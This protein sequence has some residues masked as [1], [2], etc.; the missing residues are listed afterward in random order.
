MNK[1][2]NVGDVIWFHR[3]QAG[4]TQKELARVAGIGK[5]FDR[6]NFF[7]QLDAVARE[8]VGTVTVEEL[9]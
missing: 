2:E 6:N 8:L 3:Q 1:V 7:T 5:S 4:L 9:R